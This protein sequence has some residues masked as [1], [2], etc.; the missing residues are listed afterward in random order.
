MGIIRDALKPIV[1]DQGTPPERGY[2][3]PHTGVTVVLP[4]EA[5]SVEVRVCLFAEGITTEALNTV[6]TLVTQEQV[7]FQNKCDNLLLEGGRISV[8]RFTGGSREASIVRLIAA[9]AQ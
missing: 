3:F 7:Q 9:P 6:G 1:M 5:R 2:V 4:M 8:I